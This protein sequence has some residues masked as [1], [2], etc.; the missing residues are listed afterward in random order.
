MDGSVDLSGKVGLCQMTG[1]ETNRFW[2]GWNSGKLQRFL[3]LCNMRKSTW[4]HGIETNMRVTVVTIVSPRGW[5]VGMGESKD[6]FT[7]QHA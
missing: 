5:W 4:L 7:L 6:L 3:S 1:V 2:W